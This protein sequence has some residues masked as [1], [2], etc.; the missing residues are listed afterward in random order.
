ME[1]PRAHLLGLPTE[2]RLTIWRHIHNDVLAGSD[3]NWHERPVTPW[4]GLAATSRIIHDEVSEFWPRTMIPYH[5]NDS[6]SC[7]YSLTTNLAGGLTI[8][9]FKGF[10]QLS[11][12]L[13]I[14]HNNNPER[15][16]RQ[17]ANG[18]TQL[19]PVLQD[20]RIFFIGEDGLGTNTNFLGCGLPQY[21]DL[22]P[23]SKRKLCKEGSCYAERGFL[24]RAL[25]NLYLLRNLVV[26]NANYPLL[27]SLIGYKPVLKTLLLVSDSR[28]AIYK[29]LGGPLLRWHPP[30][31]LHTLQISANAVLGAV[32]VV[33]KVI[34]SLQD[35]TFLIP[36]TGWQEHNW[37]WLEDAGAIIRNISLCSRKMRRFRLCIEQPLEEHTAVALLS[38]IKLYLPDTSLQVLEI[39]ATLDSAYFGCELIEALPKTLR[40]LYISQEL[41]SAKDL[42]KAV[43]KRYFGEKDTG[44]HQQAG[45]L[46]LVGY[47]YWERESTKLAL[48]RLNGA[49]LDRERNAH[50]LDHPENASFRFGGGS[51]RTLSV[52][53]VDEIGQDVMSV[54]GVPEGAL[55]YYEDQTVEHITEMEMAFHAEQTARAEEQFP[56]LVMPD[57]VE[58]G[59]NDHW[60]TD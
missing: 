9:L 57:N 49:L 6:S 17:I 42:L 48:L 54:E 3:S 39:H 1:Y 10:R 20:L 32:N 5:Q 35:F 18:L 8:S 19:A 40:R 26:S 53:P 11:I 12:Q 21:S 15:F 52:L 46:G 51:S 43:R 56:F 47:E 37:K 29:H 50:L 27:H 55:M 4:G 33:L 31:A 16:F 41:V 30:A 34:H 58:V 2:I 25:R 36:S 44:G 38:A 14:H 13:P 24:F 45:D 7:A 60:M 23:T 59:V 28:S 22:P